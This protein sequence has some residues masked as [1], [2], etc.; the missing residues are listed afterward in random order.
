MN[1][2]IWRPLIFKDQATGYTISSHGNVQ[3]GQGKLRKFGDYRGYYTFY[4]KKYQLQVHRLVA[5]A[6]VDNPDKLKYVQHVDGN[7]FNN[8]VDN[9]KWVVHA[10]HCILKS[11]ELMEASLNDANWRPVYIDGE[12]SNYSVS[13]EAQIRNATT[14]NLISL[15][16]RRGY[17]TCSLTHKGERY[18]K[19][20]H[21]LVAEAFIPNNDVEK[22]VVNHINY[23]G[24]D[25]RVK[26][27]EWVTISENNKHASL[28]PERK[29][30][31]IPIIRSNLDGTDRVHYDSVKQAIEE[32]G[33]GV[34][35]CL[36]GRRE[37]TR[38]YIWTY[39]NA[40]EKIEILDEFIPVQNHPEFLISKD[41]RIYSSLTKNLLTPGLIASYM[42]VNLNNKHY[43]IH[44]LIAIHFIDKPENY[45]GKL[46]V[47]HKD[48]NKLNNCIDNLEWMSASDNTRHWHEMGGHPGVRPVIQKD[49]QGNIVGEYINASSAHRALGRPINDHVL[50]AC[51]NPGKVAYGFKWEFK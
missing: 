46:I 40:R 28:K 42:K 29:S 49:L 8:S 12:L 4:F 38:G 19:Y 39:E 43:S 31:Q 1:E 2:E 6:F 3:D 25:N 45:N 14:L 20:V 16:T 7:P 15:H 5:S 33:S 47:N 13:V 32:F 51:R 21:R 37:Q 27:L 23:D 10:Q 36:A 22:N 18:A 50:N 30:N 48:G 34:S 24:T 26:N 35:E 41:G 11:K 44:R 9:L 17:T